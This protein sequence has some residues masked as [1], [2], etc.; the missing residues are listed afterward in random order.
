MA[1]ASWGQWWINNKDWVALAAG[2]GLAVGSALLAR[3]FFDGSEPGARAAINKESQPEAS[4]LP[5]SPEQNR[6]L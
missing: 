5:V 6:L 2:S 4:S 1:V 3:Y